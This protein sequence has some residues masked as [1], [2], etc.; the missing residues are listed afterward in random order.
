MN[1]RTLFGRKAASPPKIP[2]EHDFTRAGWGRALHDMGFAGKVPGSQRIGGHSSPRPE[3][4]DVVLR[5]MTSGGIGRY[6]LS[7][8]DLCL[9]PRDMW[10]ADAEFVGYKEEE[11]A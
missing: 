7:N 1:L 10:F 3:E 4:G 8:L 2:V 5:R 6:R 9:D 11:E